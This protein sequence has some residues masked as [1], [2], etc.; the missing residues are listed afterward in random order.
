MSIPFP[1]TPDGGSN[2]FVRSRVESI[3]LSFLDRVPPTSQSSLRIQFVL[4]HSPNVQTQIV[5]VVDHYITV[6]FALHRLRRAPKR[7]S[8]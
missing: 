8:W 2:L 6:I 3:A 5:H 1:C 7:V 4:K